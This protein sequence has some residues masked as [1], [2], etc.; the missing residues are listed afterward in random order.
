MHHYLAG[1]LIL[2]EEIW[3]DTMK[4]AENILEFLVPNL[5][6]RICD[7]GVSF[8]K[9]GIKTG[10][11]LETLSFIQNNSLLLK[12]PLGNPLNSP[13]SPD[14][15]LHHLFS[16]T[17]HIGY[18][19]KIFTKENSILEFSFKQELF[20]IYGG[21]SSP[22][23]LG[24]Y[25][26]TL[27]SPYL[28]M[29]DHY[30]TV[31]AAFVLAENMQYETITYLAEKKGNFSDRFSDALE[32]I[33]FRNP[34][35]RIR[36]LDIEEFL[37]KVLQQENNFGILLVHPQCISFIRPFLKEVLGKSW[38]SAYVHLGL[39]RAIFTASKL[40]FNSNEKEKANTIG[41]ML[42][43][44]L[45]LRYLGEN[46]LAKNFESVLVELVNSVKVEFLTPK[47][48]K[49]GII[50]AFKETGLEKFHE[51]LNPEASPWRAMTR[52]YHKASLYKEAT[53]MGFDVL[54]WSSLSEKEIGKSLFELANGTHFFL[55]QVASHGLQVFP[56]PMIMPQETG[57]LWCC[58]FF[59]EKN[60]NNGNERDVLDLLERIS[61]LYY[62][63]DVA[64]LYELHGRKNFFPFV[65]V[66]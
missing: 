50:N 60:G 9:K 36:Q 11:P 27:C 46:T 54:L 25:S 14:Q 55:E 35:I 23:K 62:W 30:S 38:N 31:N 59:L 2:G 40:S 66:E 16:T 42:A 4:V 33:A 5:R 61:S 15:I 65:Y 63:I 29:I 8:I 19:R 57:E 18:F 32:E 10:W 34:K 21:F 39:E 45:M 26:P 52:K 41:I 1:V 12:P 37:Q 17:V 7:A 56:S 28:S 3:H 22:H 43:I 47:F 51:K 44:S 24:A 64:K 6:W 20:I 48:L 49:N 58:R 53:L 13:L